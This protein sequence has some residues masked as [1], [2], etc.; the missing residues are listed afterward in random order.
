MSNQLHEVFENLE[1]GIVLFKNNTIDFSNKVFHDILN[2]LGIIESSQSKVDDLILDY[3]I[4][5]L[6]RCD[7]LTDELNEMVP[8]S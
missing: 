3:R 7:E 5:T 1:E 8:N 6:F 4:F 2:S